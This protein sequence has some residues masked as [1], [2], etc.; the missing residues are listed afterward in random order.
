MMMTKK[1]GL[2]GSDFRMFPGVETNTLRDRWNKYRVFDW[3]LFILI[4]ITL[5]NL[6]NWKLSA[7]RI[8]FG[9]FT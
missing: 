6:D 4:F 1:R 7:L 8:S 5:F 9:L 2:A 3:P